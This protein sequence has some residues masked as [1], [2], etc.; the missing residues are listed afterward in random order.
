MNDCK[1]IRVYSVIIHPGFSTEGPYYGH[2][3]LIKADNKRMIALEKAQ[4]RQELYCELAVAA[5]VCTALVLWF[6]SLL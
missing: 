3:D 6:C 4:A 2:M 1:P 5:I